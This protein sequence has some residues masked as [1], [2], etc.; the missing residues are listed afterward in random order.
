VIFRPPDNSVDDVWAMAGGDM[1]I[2]RVSGM[3]KK[4]GVRR[5]GRVIVDRSYRQLITVTLLGRRGSD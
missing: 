2:P 5:Y 1:R 4:P 3:C